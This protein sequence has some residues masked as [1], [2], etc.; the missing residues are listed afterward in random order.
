M[1]RGFT[2]IEL[3]MVLVVIA[4]IVGGVVASR[5]LV[6]AAKV[7]S[8]AKDITSYIAAVG[9]FKS[10]YNCLP[11]DCANATTFFS[12]LS[13]AQTQNPQNGNGNGIYDGL[14]D[15]NAVGEGTVRVWEELSKAG[16]LGANYSGQ[17]QG[18]GWFDQRFTPGENVPRLGWM[19]GNTDN[20][21]ATWF[22]ESATLML[23]YSNI[24]VNGSYYPCPYGYDPGFFPYYPASVND[25]NR[26]IIQSIHSDGR[27]EQAGIVSVF[28]YALDT[29]LDDGRPLKGK[30]RVWPVYCVD[31]LWGSLDDPPYI[32]ASNYIC[33]PIAVDLPF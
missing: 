25:K 20:Q 5:E 17:Y 13:A 6:Q 31:T 1:K 23:T 8:A 29:K 4:L 3:S 16:I 33:P 24:C 22:G 14:T 32:T 27:M 26:M 11:G 19:E 15:G 12:N 9:A 10:K 18:A 2:L 7:R 28:A 30:V 21:G